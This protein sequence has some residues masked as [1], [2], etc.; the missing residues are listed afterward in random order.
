[1]TRL[2]R[3]DLRLKA[4][5]ASYYVALAQHPDFKEKQVMLQKLLRLG[6]IHLVRVAPRV[7]R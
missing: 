7:P 4:A 2:Q 3:A 5:T 6:G 1:M